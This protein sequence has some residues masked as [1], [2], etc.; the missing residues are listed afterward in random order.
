[1]MKA[2]SRVS[3]KPIIEV[4][5]LTKD[6]GGLRAVFD[7]SFDIKEGETLGLIGPNGAGKTTVFNMISGFLSPTKGDIKFEGKSIIGTKPSKLCKRGL[8]RTFQIVKP[9]NNLTVYQNVEI[10]AYNR[11]SVGAIIRNEVE[12]ILEDF[13]LSGKRDIQATSLTI[14]EKK[15]MEIARAIS[16]KPKVL[17]LD[18]VMSG[19]NDSE[20]DDLVK[21]IRHVK[22]QYSLTLCIIEH[23][24][25]TIMSVCDRIIVL[26]QG[27]RIADGTPQEIS[28]DKKVIKVYLGE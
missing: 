17:L 23:I 22:A 21:L 28:E 7:L 27:Q 11:N 2:D 13:E 19:L 18:E 24:M 5:N 12:D 14:A 26:D 3:E 4:T 25:R 10:G 6:F 16:T 8:V 15:H 20:A 9:F 1:M